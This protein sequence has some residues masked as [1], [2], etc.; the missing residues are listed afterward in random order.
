[1]IR[2]STKWRDRCRCTSFEGKKCRYQSPLHHLS[3]KTIASPRC[4]ELL[5]QLLFRTCCVDDVGDSSTLVF[6]SDYFGLALINST[7]KTMRD[8]YDRSS[9]R[10]ISTP[11]L[12][13]IEDLLEMEIKK[14][15]TEQDFVALLSTP[16]LRICPFLVSFKRRLRLFDRIVSSISETA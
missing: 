7:A 1:M 5:K 15:E 10:P 12:W 14:S 11:N 16:V 4:V 3:N 2:R 6:Q 9:R 13:L 8:L